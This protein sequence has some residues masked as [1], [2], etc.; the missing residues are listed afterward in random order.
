ML[1]SLFQ[2]DARNI[3]I[4]PFSHFSPTANI[5][6][7]LKKMC[8]LFN[9]V[10]FLRRIHCCCCL[11]GQITKC[12]DTPMLKKADM[13]LNRPRDVVSHSCVTH[14]KYNTTNQADF[15]VTRYPTEKGK[16]S[17]TLNSSLPVS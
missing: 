5:H 4:D 2:L 8:T 3:S 7:L 1:D 9:V 6:F 15:R 11:L 10:F 17:L 12:R 13:T 16:K 14:S